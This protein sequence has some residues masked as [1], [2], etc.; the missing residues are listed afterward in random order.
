MSRLDS[1]IRRLTAQ[2]ACLNA[3][4]DMIRQLDGIVIELG[5]G[6]GRTY[7]HIREH[8][9]DRRIVVFERDPKPHLDCMPPKGDLVIGTLSENLPNAVAMIGRQVA[10]LH[11]DIGCG[12][13]EIDAANASLIASCIPNL[14]KP[15]GVVLSDQPLAC[16]DFEA[17]DMPEGIA[18][19]RY[20]FIRRREQVG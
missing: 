2:R 1:F 8:V 12:D 19:G 17:C 13:R 16:D 3:A 10:L 18:S 11:S 6:N 14:L 20:T 5:L 4:F 15:G 9:G 7:D